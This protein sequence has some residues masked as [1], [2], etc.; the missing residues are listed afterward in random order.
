MK[1]ERH[2]ASI[3]LAAAF[4]GF[5][6]VGLADQLAKVQKP[7]GQDGRPVAPGSK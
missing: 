6:V 3:L 5:P 1:W 7:A 2:C 4:L